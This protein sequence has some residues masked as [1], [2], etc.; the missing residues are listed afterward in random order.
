M[1][2]FDR[3]GGAM[4]LKHAEE[5]SDENLL[6]RIRGYD[7][8]SCEAKYHNSCRRKF[9]N[10]KRD[11]SSWR[12]NDDE[13]RA[14][15]TELE[16]VHKVAFQKVEDVIKVEVIQKQV[17]IKLYLLLGVYKDALKGTKFEND[18]YR[19]ERL[20]KKIEKNEYLFSKIAFCLSDTANKKFE[21]CLVY[22]KEMKIGDAVHVSY[23]LGLSLSDKVRET[24]CEIRG[25]ILKAFKTH[26]KSQEWPPKP[27]SQ[28]NYPD[29]IPNSLQ[30]LIKTLIS[31]SE[32]NKSEKVSRLMY[33]ISQDICRAATNGKWNLP[34]HILLGMA[35]RHLFRSAEVT[36]L[37]NRFGHIPD[38]CFLLEL[39]SAL[40]KA[41][42]ETSHLLTNNIIRNPSC[43]AVFHSDFDNFDQYTNELTGAGSV[44]RA[45]GIMLQEV[46]P[47]DNESIGGNI[48]LT[49]PHKK[50]G[51]RSYKFQQT[52]PPENNLY[53]GVRKN[54]SMHIVTTD[55]PGGGEQRDLMLIEGYVWIFLR[56]TAAEAGPQE[57]PG[58]SGYVSML[59]TIP[60]RLTT[61]DHYP[62]IPDP[63]TD[64]ST[65]K[66]TLRFAEE[67]GKE[68]GQEYHI[69]TYDLGVCIK[70]Y[71]LIWNY[72]VKYKKHIV[73]IGTFHIVCAYMKMIAKKMNG[74]GFSDIL[75]E[76]GLM[77]SGS[78]VSVLSGKGYSRAMNCHKSLMEGLERLLMKNFFDFSQDAEIK[79]KIENART[80]VLIHKTK[81][82]CD[83]KTLVSNEEVKTL[84]MAFQK[85]RQEVKSGILGPTAR[86]WLSYMDH[87]W[88][89][90]SLLHAVK[91]NNYLEY[92]YC[93][94][95]LPDLFFAF[96]GQNYARYLTYFSVF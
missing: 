41:L 82:N 84:V 91:T 6:T 85:F 44:H 4:V 63:I 68:V 42:D 26:S 10:T 47:E 45:H 28:M 60:T 77:T 13:N 87:V 15:Q 53:M 90:L 67:A 56:A 93:M 18:N 79:P 89:I 19:P 29:L 51:E 17:I 23:E 12:S 11:P 14:A 94:T 78:M 64:Y 36:V 72:P 81:P 88:L 38:Y 48:P 80:Q 5:I 54:P 24:A 69:V 7:L 70:A 3:E 8:F 96:G 16:A 75:I 66:E 50:T 52:K 30:S 73:L 58:W 76:S 21:S 37:L 27:E 2:V 61:I 83:L 34:K 39:E 22:S 20:K 49:Q 74:S 59:G 1:S 9:L 86:M 31:G 92:A 55:I 43:K 33:S 35:L 62:V 25:H 46:I 95:L 40:A 57:Y 65:V 71:P 32:Q